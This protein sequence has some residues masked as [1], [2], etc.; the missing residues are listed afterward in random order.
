MPAS[1]TG[2]IHLEGT[3][4]TMTARPISIPCGALSTRAASLA[5]AAWLAAGACHAQDGERLEPV[6]LRSRITRVQPMT[7]IVLWATS[8][9]NKTN[10]IQLEFSYMKYGDI[11]KERG[12]YDWRVMDRLLER[13]AARNHQAIVRYYFV[14]PGNPTT[15][16]NYL[17]AM[18][19]YHETRGQ[20]EGKPTS[21]PDWSH[22]ALQE[23][24]LEFY[25][26]L[27]E[28]YDNDP[29]LAFVETGFG[30]WAEYHIYSGPM[31]PGKTFPDKA[32]Q[33]AFAHQL[34]RV[35]RKTPW[36]ISVDAADESRAPFAARKDLMQ[37]PFGVFDDSFLCKQH[38]REN[39]PNWNIMGRDR[40]KRAPAGGEISYYAAH[41]QKEA[42]AVDGPYGIPFENAAADFHITFM[43]ANDQPKYRPMDRLRSAGLA[44]GYRFQ[45]TGF[46]SGA[47]R[48]RV[49]VTNRG[50]APIYHDAFLAV[51]GVRSERSLKGLLPGA[52]RT[53][54]I[55]SGGALPRLTIACDRLVPG[56]SID[57]DAD[58]EGAPR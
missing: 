3:V 18:S 8:E 28:R 35:F 39:E 4:A 41:D 40:W 24:T 25:E 16:P 36:L 19:N 48:S 27:A 57:Y 13:V 5:L 37:L 17:K 31:V 47:R 33:A 1:R 20:S 34:D 56:Q 52:S 45:I 9:H 2:V 38:A 26:K 7:G 22:R 23:F 11:V 42:L 46:E 30:L 6:P 43:I 51:N 29:R 21:F 12:Q 10:A 14:Y 32:L 49:T 54:E 50:V 53:D 55:A 44:C 15:V 58:L